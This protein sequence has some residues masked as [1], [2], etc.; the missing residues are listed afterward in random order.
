MLCGHHFEILNR[1]WTKGPFYFAFDP[2]NYVAS[3]AWNSFHFGGGRGEAPHSKINTKWNKIRFQALEG[4]LKTYF[5]L[6]VG[7]PLTSSCSREIPGGLVDR[8]IKWTHLCPSAH[9]TFAL[10]GILCSELG[11]EL[12]AVFLSFFFKGPMTHLVW[13]PPV[14]QT[15]S[16]QAF[17]CKELSYFR[18]PQVTGWPGVSPKPGN[19]RPC[20]NLRRLCCICRE[21][22]N[23]LGKKLIRCARY[24]IHG[25]KSPPNSL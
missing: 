11:M 24:Y 13:K 22:W 19:N 21:L 15:T 16:H 9:P 23:V 14:R 7:A 6:G 18:G 2:A 20:S 25:E 8:G 4:T 17:C 10:T 5:C 12:Q 3:P 1:F